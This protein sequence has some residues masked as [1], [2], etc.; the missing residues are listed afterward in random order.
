MLTV[1]AKV[2][3]WGKTPGIIKALSSGGKTALVDKGHGIGW[4]KVSEIKLIGGAA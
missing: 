1:G 2:I 4:V 3:C